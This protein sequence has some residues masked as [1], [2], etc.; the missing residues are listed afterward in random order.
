M[1]TGDGS[2]AIGV[3][4]VALN[5][6]AFAFGLSDTAS[7]L[8]SFAFG[9]NTDA[10][11]I[12]S[13]TFGVNTKAS[14]I[15][16]TAFG[17][18]TLASAAYSTAFGSSTVASGSYST[19]FGTTTTASGNYSTTF[20]RTIEVSGENSV[21]IGLNSSN[22]T[23]TADNV[24]CVLGGNVGIG[25]IN[26]QR[27][28]HVYSSNGD[29]VSR[30]ALND[31]DGTFI[32]FYSKSSGSSLFPTLTGSVT[33]SSGTVS[34]NTFTGSH[35]A[36]ISES[37]EK[38]MLISLTGNNSYVDIQNKAGEIIYGANICQ[39]ENSPNILGAY[40][41]VNND[42]DLVMAVGNG[43]M[44]VV[45]NGE[46][47]N[48]GD[49]LISSSIQ[50]HAMKDNG[51]YTVAHIIARVAE[52]VEW[53]NVTKTINGVKHKKISV[54]FESFDLFH[55]EKQLQKQSNDIKALQQQINQLKELLEIKAA[56]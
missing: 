30:F 5:H 13:T 1:A 23:I 16:A 29:P 10:T 34:Y 41:G 20:G 44:W 47:L 39:E 9:S 27:L 18:T 3:K 28:L 48:I 25:S 50:G 33:V 15:G 49:Y 26:P 52:P 17:A 6:G 56:K 51:K 11:G 40:L 14:A 53:D 7:A 36:D 4:S 37:V 21:G 12:Y 22:Y 31:Q 46:N 19:A 43:S 2:F 38:G 32:E 45:D 55:Y 54:F 42:K 8:A 35:L 24:M